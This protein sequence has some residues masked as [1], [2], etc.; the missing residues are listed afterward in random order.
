MKF[1]LI[2]TLLAGVAIGYYVGQRWDLEVNFEEKD[3]KNG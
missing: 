1:K 3:K 2:G